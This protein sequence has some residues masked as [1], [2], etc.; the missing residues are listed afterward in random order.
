M[1]KHYSTLAELI[2]AY[3]DRELT[4]ETAVI[5][6]DKNEVS[7]TWHAPDDEDWLSAAMVQPSAVIQHPRARIGHPDPSGIVQELAMS[8][9][10][11]RPA[12]V[13]GTHEVRVSAPHA[14]RSAFALVV[15]MNA[16]YA[17]VRVTVKQVRQLHFVVTGRARCRPG[18]TASGVLRPRR[19]CGPS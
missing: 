5:E 2:Q 17:P 7:V 4:R 14:P 13:D 16:D 3:H 11:V 18:G 1:R 9:E 12:R 15:A 8:I 6:L 10:Q 19:A